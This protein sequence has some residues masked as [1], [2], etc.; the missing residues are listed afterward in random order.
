VSGPVGTVN[1]LQLTNA[2]GAAFQVLNT[3]TIS[4]GGSV[5]VTNSVLHIE[6]GPLTI[7]G[8]VANASLTV[9]TNGSVAVVGPIT[10]GGGPISTGLVLVTDGQLVIT[11][12]PSL[13]SIGS[14]TANNGLIVDGSVTI[15]NGG[16][17]IVSNVT[18]VIGNTGSGSLT[19]NGGTLSEATSNSLVVGN[20]P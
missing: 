8:A 18:T 2:F 5:L 13:V 20:L 17:L 6:N 15:T 19:I 9:R 12:N 1:T 4:S 11:N 14:I 3:F 7:N 10:I 16:S